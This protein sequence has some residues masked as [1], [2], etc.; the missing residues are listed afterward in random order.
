MVLGRIKIG[1]LIALTDFV[2]KNGMSIEFWNVEKEVMIEK[3]CFDNK[4]ACNKAFEVIW[5]NF[6]AYGYCDIDRINRKTGL[7]MR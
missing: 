4:E 7:V 6:S 3:V 2:R 5:S 1:D